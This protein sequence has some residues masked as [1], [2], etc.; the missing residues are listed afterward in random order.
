MKTKFYITA[1]LALAI[2]SRANAQNANTT[3][4]NLTSHTSVNVS[5][6]PDKKNEHNLGSANK[7]WKNLYLDTA[8]YIDGYRFLDANIKKGNTAVGMQALNANTGSSNTAVGDKALYSNSFGRYNTANGSVALYANTFG[9]A[10]TATGS[11][12]LYSNT[13]GD[14]NTATGLNALE[15]NT[16][17]GDNTA[18]GQQ[19]LAYNAKG[20]MN[21]AIGSIALY[22]NFSGN[23]NTGVGFGV[24]ETTSYSSDN[25][26]LGYTAGFTYDNGNYNCFIGS[27][28][29]VNDTGYNNCVALGH[30]AIST[31]SHQVSVGNTATNSIGGYANWTNF[32]DGRYKKNIKTNVP[33]LEFINQLKPVTYTLD[34]TGIETK[35]HAGEKQ[36]KLPD[37][38]GVANP[39]DN[40]VMQQ[41]MEEKSKIVY[42]GFVAQDVEKAAQ[43]IGYN[44]SGVDKPKD[45]NKSFYGLRYGDF[46]VPL[47][48]AVQELS[49]MND[50]LKKQNEN[51]EQRVAKLEAIM[52]AQ[53]PSAGYIQQNINL[54][55]ALLSQNIP[56]PFS[57]TTIINYNL[58]Q[59]YAS[60]KIVITDKN[61]NI[62]KEI[63]ISGNGKGSIKVD[64]SMLSSG[65]YQ[66][67]LYA[68]DKLIGTKQMILMK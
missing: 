64:A 14:Y 10:N 33:G 45:D 55:N 38:T 56:N 27:Q 2:Y 46:V 9:N 35:L 40:P 28:A 31:A 23:H 60:A 34:V 15:Y 36:V 37:G 42:T 20:S 13:T 39:M 22:S 47:V 41:A 32:S 12:S 53:Q 24:L 51:L 61:G 54:T 59:Q 17:G 43:S 4:S 29:D 3:L 21:T 52:N 62:L 1:I 57:N 16:T 5:L 67:S 65:A 44:F 49:N 18:M 19:A 25:T 50:S 11:R 26:A 66:Y 8:L 48:K 63:N 58:P 7:S 30:G 68:D 6:L